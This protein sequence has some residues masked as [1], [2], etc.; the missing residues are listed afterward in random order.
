MARTY[1]NVVKY[2]FDQ[3]RIGGT[4]RE[5]VD[6]PRYIAVGV[7]LGNPLQIKEVLKLA[8][9]MGVGARVGIDGCRVVES[10]GVVWVQFELISAQWA[11]VRLQDLETHGAIGLD[12]T[13]SVVSFSWDSP[14]ILV[15]GVTGAGKSETV[16]TIL[17]S[18]LIKDDDT[19]LMLCDPHSDFDYLEDSKALK[20][21]IGRTSYECLEV[22]KWANLELH[23]RKEAP[24]KKWSPLVVVVDEAESVL[25]M[26]ECKD[27]VM[28]IAK[29]GRKFNVHLLVST[30]KPTHKALTGIMDQLD[31]KY[32][33]RMADAKMSGYFGAGLDLH[34]LSGQGD[35]VK[36][37]SGKSTRFQVALTEKDDLDMIPGR[38][39]HQRMIYEFADQEK[40]LSPK[41]GG[42]PKYQPEAKMVAYYLSRGPGKITQAEARRVLGLSRTQHDVNK[43]FAVGIMSASKE[44]EDGED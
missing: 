5:W 9:S 44:Y 16:C 8:P 38:M 13:N 24:K 31:T 4:I 42:R 29:E 18:M 40:P 30:Q 17:T 32:L 10:Q 6:T 20:A 37:A 27:I 34:K 25:K 39:P 36:F 19:E 15:A 2:V 21:P 22:L 1:V 41:G 28:T 35:F 14:H 43:A 33:G 23:Q 26:D 3:K 12:S 7:R 11:V